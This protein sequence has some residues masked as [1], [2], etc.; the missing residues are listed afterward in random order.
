VTGIGLR[1]V[2]VETTIPVRWRPDETLDFSLERMFKFNFM[3]IPPD[4]M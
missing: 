2:A 3:I 4:E 1:I